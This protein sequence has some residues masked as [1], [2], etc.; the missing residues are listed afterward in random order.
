MKDEI[1]KYNWQG[2][3]IEISPD[4]IRNYISTS[5]S[6]TDKE[7]MDF[8]N[9]CIYKKLNP[10]I[11]EAYL[12]KYGTEKANIVTSKDV[13]DIRAFR[14]PKYDGEEVT[15]NYE[16]S[17]NLMDLWV[18]TRIYHKGCSHPVADVT[19]HYPEYVG[20][21]K[22]GTIKFIWRTKP[23]TMLTKVSKA[24]GKREANPEN[25]SKLYLSEEFDQEIKPT[26][27][28]ITEKDITPKPKQIESETKTATEKAISPETNNHPSE[29]QMKQIYGEVV[30]EDCGI[31]VYGFKCPKCTNSIKNDQL[32]VISLGFLHSHLLTKAD[33]KAPGKMTPAM[34]PGK[35]TK[36]Q[37]IDIYD[38]WIGDSK[39]LIFGERKRREEGE[40]P[41][42]TKA[43]KIKQAREIVKTRLEVKDD[44]AAFP[45]GEP[46]SSINNAIK[47]RGKAKAN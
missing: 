2:Q 19:V 38:W 33:I 5:K 47:F 31:R 22:D 7:V 3:E 21:K 1:F 9:I 18:R 29:I 28:V 40:K 36:S 4:I 13:F 17:M 8:I 14:D 32:H 35:L 30:C 37:A 44:K 23:V 41:K 39:K 46:G 6:V 43:D 12:I 11:G 24:Q 42:A 45:D 10:F 15:D 16:R 34:D 27:T 20:K 26:E 25:M